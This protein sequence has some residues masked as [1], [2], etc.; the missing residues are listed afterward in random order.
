[1]LASRSRRL[2]ATAVIGVA[3]ALTATAAPGTAASPPVALLSMSDQVVTEET[4]PWVASHARIR[5]IQ[6]GR[7]PC[8]VE[9][10]TTLV[11]GNTADVAD[12]GM[13]FRTRLQVLVH[14]DDTTVIIAKVL[15]DAI[16]E[17]EE[18]F[19]VQMRPLAHS[20]APACDV[21]DGDAT[22]TIAASL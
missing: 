22:L 9:V 3:A 12:L 15:W 7:V 20:G 10:F 11:H 8:G 6:S 14:P 4:Q 17:P 13:F 2:L 16:A 19:T 21:K 18:T 5:Q 1:M